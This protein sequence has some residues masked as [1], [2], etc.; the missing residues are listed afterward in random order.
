MLVGVVFVDAAITERK[1]VV[2]SESLL[3]PVPGDQHLVFGG[4]SADGPRQPALRVG[5]QDARPRAL[6][7]TR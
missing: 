4:L 1:L 2:F 3:G 5:D 7:G 6:A